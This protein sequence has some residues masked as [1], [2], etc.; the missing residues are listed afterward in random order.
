MYVPCFTTPF[1]KYIEYVYVFAPT[2]TH[3]YAYECWQCMNT[4]IRSYLLN[5]EPF[6]CLTIQ[7]SQFECFGNLNV[8]CRSGSLFR[9]PQYIETI[10]TVEWITCKHSKDDWRFEKPTVAFFLLY[11]LPCAFLTL[12][13]SPSLW[14]LLRMCDVVICRHNDVL[15]HD[16]AHLYDAICGHHR[17]YHRQN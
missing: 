17:Y 6:E 12:W 7:S 13:K 1:L 5:T 14:R 2:H 16:I 8:R 15:L 10:L 4:K 11:S 3:K 9:S